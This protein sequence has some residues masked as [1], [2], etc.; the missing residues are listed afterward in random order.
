[1]DKLAT[2]N[3]SMPDKMQKNLSLEDTLKNLNNR[4]SYHAQAD[5]ENLKSEP[6]EK[7]DLSMTKHKTPS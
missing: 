7:Q 1:M 3:K 6:S 5:I 4:S 2:K